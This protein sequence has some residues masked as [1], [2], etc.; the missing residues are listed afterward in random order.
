[1]AENKLHSA[2]ELK[3]AIQLQS[4]SK[5]LVLLKNKAS[6]K[7]S[8]TFLHIRTFCCIIVSV[9]TTWYGYQ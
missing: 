1:M 8:N 2:C 7:K 6:H 9:T 4:A 3:Y 5:M